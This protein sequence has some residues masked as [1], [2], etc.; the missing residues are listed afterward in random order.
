MPD[1]SI[2]FSTIRKA[3][4]GVSLRDSMGAIGEDVVF[5]MAIV[6]A[7][8][9]ILSSIWSIRFLGLLGLILGAHHCTEFK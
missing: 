8:P 1:P 9:I 4:R 5:M 3:F 7:L 2:Y 6:N